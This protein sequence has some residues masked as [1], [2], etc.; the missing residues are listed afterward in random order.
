MKINRSRY[1]CVSSYLVSYLRTIAA[2]Y[3][4]MLQKFL[5]LLHERVCTEQLITKHAVKCIL[6]LMLLGDETTLY[7]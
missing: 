5:Q 7:N 3:V 2:M 4:S 6:L 1:R